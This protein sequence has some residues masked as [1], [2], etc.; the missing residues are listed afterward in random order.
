MKKYYILLFISFGVTIFFI[1]SVI[2]FSQKQPELTEAGTVQEITFAQVREHAT[3]S[4]CWVI[5][6]NKVYNVTSYFTNSTDV[7]SCGSDATSLLIPDAPSS[8]SAKTL[9]TL[10]KYYIGIL[11]P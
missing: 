6:S 2:R 5:V 10:Q 7:S 1:F 8:V 4:N 9:Q 11:V 3:A